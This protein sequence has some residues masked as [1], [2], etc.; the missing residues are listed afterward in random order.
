MREHKYDYFES[1]FN[2]EPEFECP[3]CGQYLY[4]DWVDNGFGPYSIQA[5]PYICGDCGWSEKK[6]ESCIKERCFSW[7]VCKGK[8]V[9]NT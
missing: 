1:I 2:E 6:C 8:A 9:I 5:S 3:K 4:T 7:N